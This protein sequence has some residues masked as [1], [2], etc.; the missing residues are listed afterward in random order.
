MSERRGKRKWGYKKYPQKVLYAM[1]GA[2][3]RCTNSKHP[4]WE[5]YG[6]RGIQICSEW[7]ANQ[8]AFVE[9]LI[10]LPGSDNPKLVLD[11]INNDGNYEPYSLRWITHKESMNNIRR[12]PRSP[13]HQFARCFKRLH[14]KGL[15]YVDI[16][17][18][19]CMGWQSV[20]ASIRKTER[21]Q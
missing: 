20:G 15:T 18:L 4:Q 10:S 5:R 14:D 12:G 8:V 7:L 17:N 19:Y 16:A 13:N 2:V 9:Y 21:R 3:A 1:W 11:R 6:G